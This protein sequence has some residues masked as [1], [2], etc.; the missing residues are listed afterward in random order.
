MTKSPFEK[1]SFWKKY[2]WLLIVVVL[3]LAGASWW[4]YRTFFGEPQWYAGNP[5]DR[6][7]VLASMTGLDATP[8]KASLTSWTGSADAYQPATSIWTTVGRNP[9]YDKLSDAQTK[10]ASNAVTVWQAL[11]AQSS[12]EVWRVRIN[13]PVVSS[14]YAEDYPYDNRT[15]YYQY[16]PVT[17]DYSQD[18]CR[19]SAAS[20]LPG[21]FMLVDEL[22][23]SAEVGEEFF[24]EPLGAGSYCLVV[25]SE[26]RYVLNNHYSTLA[27]NHG[28]LIKPSSTKAVAVDYSTPQRAVLLDWQNYNLTSRDVTEATA[29]SHEDALEYVQNLLQVIE[30]QTDEDGLQFKAWPPHQYHKVDYDVDSVSWVK[31]PTVEDCTFASFLDLDNQA[32][33]GI[34]DWDRGR[35]PIE[36]ADLGSRYCFKV[37]LKVN[38]DIY[39]PEFLFV[40]SRDLGVVGGSADTV[41]SDD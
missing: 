14:K 10:R 40:M 11:D 13:A 15:V 30:D 36:S 34:V 22:L 41:N 7:L 37:K 26:Y 18:G 1:K 23:R 17:D 29:K 3:L 28:F 27:I 12:N 31:V 39:Y 35:I 24:L 19:S 8:S 21:N 5:A 6:A 32:K 33:S 38:F 16:F 2:W 20:D 9:D 4:V 25:K